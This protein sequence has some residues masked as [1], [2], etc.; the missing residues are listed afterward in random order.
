MSDRLSK[1]VDT[2]E[3]DF[4]ARAS[5]LGLSDDVVVS[6]YVASDHEIFGLLQRDRRV[7]LS[8][9][10]RRDGPARQYSR[11]RAVGPTRRR[12]RSGRTGRV[13]PP[14]AFQGADRPRRDRPGCAGT[15]DKAYA[16][17][18]IASLK[19][20]TAQ[21]PFDFEGWWQDVAQAM[22]QQLGS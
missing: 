19:A 21:A 14:S 2:V 16:H 17:S 15:N 4:Y 8:S 22:R 3:A 18:I 1:A 12:Y 13:R 7:L 20:P 9:R 10:R 11:Q 6:G 5:E